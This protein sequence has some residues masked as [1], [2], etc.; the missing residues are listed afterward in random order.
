[1]QGTKVA[2]RKISLP[3]EFAQS[4]TG[5]LVRHKWSY[6]SVLFFP[7]HSLWEEEG[8]NIYS[9]LKYL[10]STRHTSKV[11]LFNPCYRPMRW[12]FSILTG[13]MRN[14][15]YCGPWDRKQKTWGAE[16]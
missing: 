10:F 4:H 15:R 7:S 1:M 13:W 3:R 2:K 16:V 6:L 8:T 11:I 9:A 12:V 14:L 5:F